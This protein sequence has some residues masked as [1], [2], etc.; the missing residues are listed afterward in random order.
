MF[1][2]LSNQC[3]FAKVDLNCQLY[4]SIFSFQVEVSNAQGLWACLHSLDLLM[5]EM[6][7]GIQKRH[8]HSSSTYLREE[9]SQIFEETI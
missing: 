6:A 8:A 7:H 4:V 2:E 1:N 3:Q 9:N 5:T